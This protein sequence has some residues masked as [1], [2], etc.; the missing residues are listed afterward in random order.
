[1]W[2]I[3]TE[4]PFC[5]RTRHGLSVDHRYIDC[6]SVYLKYNFIFYSDLNPVNLMWQNQVSATEL[7]KSK[8]VYLSRFCQGARLA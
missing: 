4:L 5:S 2:S 7:N 1:M 3:P 6:C 8:K